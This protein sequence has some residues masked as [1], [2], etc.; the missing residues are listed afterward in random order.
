[1]SFNDKRT[2]VTQERK[3]PKADFF[4][5]LH[6]ANFKL[7]LPVLILPVHFQS[8]VDTTSWAQNSKS[9]CLETL[10]RIACSLQVWCSVHPIG[11][12][13]IIMIGGEE[14]GKAL[15]EDDDKMRVS[16]MCTWITDMSGVTPMMEL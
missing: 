15:H 14:I 11:S 16:L 12:T 6:T 4:A 8:S 3:I 5:E 2:T 9:P 13:G 7:V 10:R 1:M